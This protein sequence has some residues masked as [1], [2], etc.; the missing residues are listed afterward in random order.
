MPTPLDA[1]GRV[2]EVRVD[3][4]LAQADRLEHLRAAVALQRRDAHLRHDLQHALV[5]RLDVVLDRLLSIDAG[6]QPVLDHVVDRLERDVR[7][8]H[9]RAVAEQQRHVMHF[10]RVAGLDDQRAARARALAHE[11]V[12]HAGGGEQARNRRHAAARRRGRT[13]SGC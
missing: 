11:M 3:E 13:G 12:V 9:A 6:E 10:A 8:H 5:E 4:L 1:R 2:R 7:V